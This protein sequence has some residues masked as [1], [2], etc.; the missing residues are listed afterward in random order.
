M[1]VNFNTVAASQAQKSRVGAANP[2]FAASGDQKKTTKKGKP[3]Y[4]SGKGTG[5]VEG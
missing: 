2:E 1:N 4:E 5:V 3:V